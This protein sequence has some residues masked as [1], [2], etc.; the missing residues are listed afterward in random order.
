MS[1][2]LTETAGITE[3]SL[4][5]AFDPDKT[6]AGVDDF[7]KP[8][9]EIMKEIAEE[10]KQREREAQK[11]AAKIQLQ[12]DAY[13]QEYCVIKNR[14]DKALYNANNEATKARTEENA[15]F[16]AGEVKVEDHKIKINEINEAC[17][18]ARTK[19]DKEFLAATSKLREKNPEGYRRSCYQDL[20][21]YK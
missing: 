11:N 5:E 20:Q 9:A 21:K 17:D 13:E 16:Q 18:K 19:A 4:C 2:I 6:A 14:R 8:N 7:D 12:K 1:K 15:R 10:E 3:S